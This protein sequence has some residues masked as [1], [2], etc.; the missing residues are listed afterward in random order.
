MKS[1]TD[2]VGYEW[3]IEIITPV[4]KLCRELL[5]VNLLDLTGS[6]FARLAGNVPLLVDTIHLICRD[7]CEA[8]GLNAK[9][10]VERLVDSDATIINAATEAMLQGIVELTP[11]AKVRDVMQAGYGTTHTAARRARLKQIIAA[12]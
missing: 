6:A 5:K 10:F 7:Q 4:I 8:L 11:G 9:Q 1:F 3:K 2:N 12:G